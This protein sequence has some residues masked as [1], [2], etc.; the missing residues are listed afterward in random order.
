MLDYARTGNSQF[1]PEAAETVAL[2]TWVGQVLDEMDIPS[3]VELMIELN[4]NGVEA[5]VQTE[6]MRGAIV[7]L[8]NNALEAMTAEPTPER[9]P[10]IKVTTREAGGQVQIDIEDNGPGI[11]AD[12]KSRIFEPFFTT[13]RQSGRTGLGL[14]IVANIVTLRLQGKI[15]CVSEPGKGTCFDIEFPANL[16]PSHEKTSD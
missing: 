8:V 15:H 9:R 5:R 13:Q 1:Q 2:D 6:R 7:N 14:Q 11:A 16:T 10:Q 3:Q 12:I 4:T